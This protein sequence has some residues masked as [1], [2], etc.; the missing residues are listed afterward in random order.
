[1][2]SVKTGLIAVSGAI[3]INLALAIVKIT[4]G[5]LGNSYALVADGIESTT[6]V[7]TSLVVWIGLRF[8]SK[9]PDLNHPYGHGKA[10][11]LAGLIVSVFM[12]G[13]AILISIQSVREILTPQRLSSVKFGTVQCSWVKFNEVRC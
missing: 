6:D 5:V 1:M 4:T 7:F 8:S 13:A 2:K 10:E 9:P 3:A 12:I 11:S